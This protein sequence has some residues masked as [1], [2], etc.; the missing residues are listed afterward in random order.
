MSVKFTE[1]L[2]D[3]YDYEKPRRGEIRKGVLVEINPTGA[4]VDVGLKHDGFVPIDD[5]ERLANEVISEL[6]PGQEVKIRVIRPDDREGNLTLSLAQAQAEEDWKKAQ[7]ILEEGEI[8]KVNVSGYNRGGL[9]ASFGHLQAFVPASHLWHRNRRDLKEYIGDDLQ[10]KFIEINPDRN[11][12]IASEQEAEKE[13]SEQR[14][15]ELLDDL[16]KGQV[17]KG[18]VRHLTDFGAFVDL[19][20]ADGLVHNSELAWRHIDHPSEVVQIGDELDVYVL[21]LDRKRKRINLSLKRL[22]PN[23][24]SNIH[25][26]YNVDQLVTGTVNKVLSYGAFVRLDA[27]VDGLLH[28][29]EIADPSP[30][31]PREFVSRGDKL[32]LRILEID[33]FRERMRLSLKRVLEEEKRMLLAQ[34]PN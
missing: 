26:V 5:I 13:S 14:L 17:R 23:P 18:T 19:G 9:L 30:D 28:V 31:D 8:C 21:D 10:V 34:T 20:G 27:G 12:L 3:A 2:I 25:E 29:S 22:R 15:Q 11:R 33:S 24:W 4:F 7:Q 16:V 32:V 1:E 6:E